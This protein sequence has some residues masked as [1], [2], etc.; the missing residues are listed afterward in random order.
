MLP[1]QCARALRVARTTG[2]EM[3]VVK[4]AVGFFPSTNDRVWDCLTR[5]LYDL[6]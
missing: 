4:H 5:I 1:I 3:W 6:I 2:T